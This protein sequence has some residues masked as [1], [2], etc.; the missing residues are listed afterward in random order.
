MPCRAVPASHISFFNDYIRT[1]AVEARAIMCQW[2]AHSAALTLTDRGLPGPLTG[3][4]ASIMPVSSSPAADV[5]SHAF[6]V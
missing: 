3:R 6:T 2:H 1:G 5:S 4:P